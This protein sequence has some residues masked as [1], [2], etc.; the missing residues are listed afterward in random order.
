MK[1]NLKNCKP[2]TELTARNGLQGFYETC[3]ADQRHWITYHQGR[4]SSVS[5]LVKDDGSSIHCIGRSRF[6]VVAFS[7]IPTDYG[8]IFPLLPEGITEVVYNGGR[9][10]KHI[11]TTPIEVVTT[12]VKA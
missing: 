4:G 11:E 10:K 7:V 12:W 5:C 2:G 1:I 8:I 3:L 6:D 9:Y